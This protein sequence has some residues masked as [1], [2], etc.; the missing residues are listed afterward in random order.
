LKTCIESPTPRDQLC[1]ER[2]TSPPRKKSKTIFGSLINDSEEDGE[3]T[4]L[5]EIKGRG[6][7]DIKAIATQASIEEEPEPNLD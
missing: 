1:L 5:D 6:G 4:C 3:N 7:E 2:I